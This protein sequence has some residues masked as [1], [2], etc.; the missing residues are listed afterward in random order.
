[1]IVVVKPKHLI[2]N[3]YTHSYTRNCPL[4]EAIIEQTGDDK[5]VVGGAYIGRKGESRV[6]LIIPET[7]NKQS[8]TE[9]IN[10]ANQGCLD[11]IIVEL[12]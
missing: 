10:K 2:D 4:Q 9:H 1:M 12:T 5:Y 11:E 7:W 6:K 3:S 8:V